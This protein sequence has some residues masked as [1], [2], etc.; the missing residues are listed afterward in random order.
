VTELVLFDV[1]E[2][3]VDLA[4][5]AE[6][7]ARA[8]VPRSAA[9]TWFP[10]V[11]RDGFAAAATGD[12]IAFADLATHHLGE[13]FAQH[14]VTDPGAVD[15]VMGRFQELR[16]HDDVRPALER[17]RAADVRV[18]TFTVGT[19]ELSASWLA[20]GGVDDLVEATLD[21]RPAGVWKPHP[22]AYHWACDHLGVAPACTALVAAHPWDVHG[23]V[24]AGLT[25]GF[26]AR[27]GR[28]YPEV[29]AP[30]TAAATSLPALVDTLLAI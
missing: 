9:M 15:A 29:F 16:P 2:T 19:A 22:A 1:N 17:L 7:T 10:A 14:Q 30:P 8:G 27:G 28:G 4:P 13:L 26:V 18:A 23:A 5:V 3:L 11:L 21:V 12:L 25:G 6:E 24:R 20:A